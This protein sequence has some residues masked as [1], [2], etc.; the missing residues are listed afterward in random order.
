[1]TG[2][3]VS[4]FPQAGAFYLGSDLISRNKGTRLVAQ[5]ED[6]KVVADPG[7]FPI[8]AALQGWTGRSVPAGEIVSVSCGGIH[9]TLCL[10]LVVSEL[11]S[12]LLT[13]FFRN[14]TMSLVL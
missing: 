11:P 6:E 12:I 13:A 8:E 4:V 10:T 2:S 1:M 7:V 14:E 5:P 9:F 3:T